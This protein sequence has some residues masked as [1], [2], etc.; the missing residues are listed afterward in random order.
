MNQ[1]QEALDKI[2]HITENACNC[3]DPFTYSET[4]EIIKQCDT[5][6]EL[7]DKVSL[8][9]K[10]LLEGIETIEFGVI[11]KPH[12]ISLKKDWRRDSSIGL[13]VYVKEKDMA[14]YY[15]IE[16]YGTLWKLKDDKWKVENE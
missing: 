6:Q 14:F 15:S 16:S 8:I 4:T 3:P 5:L 1:H 13:H 11:D 2:K 9:Q 7:I 12:Y 10:A